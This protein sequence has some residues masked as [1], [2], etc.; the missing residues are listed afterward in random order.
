MRRTRKRNTNKTKQ[1]GGVIVRDV[2]QHGFIQHRQ[3][4]ERDCVPAALIALGLY[5]P[6]TTSDPQHEFLARCYPRGIN[7]EEI[8]GFLDAAY[9][10]SEHYL[11]KYDINDTTILKSGLMQ[12]VRNNEAI[13]VGHD[14][15]QFIV[16]REDDQLYVREAQLNINIEL[17]RYMRYLVKE[18]GIQTIDVIYTRRGTRVSIRDGPKITGQIIQQVAEKTK[19]RSYVP[20]LDPRSGW[21]QAAE[22]SAQERAAQERASHKKGGTL[23]RRHKK[24][25]Y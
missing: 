16:F 7:V 4:H 23:K 5:Q 20:T 1:K 25:S 14:A 6:S 8:I 3:S 13:L 15:H 17:D 2:S 9:P 19:S 22:R 24:K 10:N 11:Q 21:G 12:R 18:H